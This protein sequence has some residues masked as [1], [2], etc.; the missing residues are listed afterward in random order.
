MDVDDKR[1]IAMKEKIHVVSVY[2]IIHFIVDFSCSIL[3]AG[4]IAPAAA[5][6]YNLFIG[7][8]LYNMFAFAFQL[9]FGL[10]ADK[11]NK[12]ALV[13][14]AG[15]GFIILAYMVSGFNVLSCVIAGIGNA[16]FHVGGGIDVL[17]ISNKR[18][19]LLGIYVAPGA[20]GLFLGGN[21]V[22]YGFNQFYAV[23]IILAVS[24]LVLLHLYK[25]VKTKY[26][27]N[28]ELP[29]IEINRSSFLI[30][31]CIL[32]T[33]CMR[34]YVGLILN[35]SWKAD[36]YTALAFVLGVV[37]G[38]IAGGIISDKFGLIRTSL[39][40]LITSAILFVFSF[41]NSFF[42]IAA[43]LLFN[44]TMPVTLIVL[45]NMFNNNKGFAFGLTTFAL[46]IGALPVLF[47]FRDVL[48]N[49]SGIFIIIVLSALAL[50]I[51]IKEY[52]KLSE[53]NR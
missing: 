13:S 24:I 17:N 7:I 14:S 2:S 4:L 51:G 12:N 53:S 46:F 16:L 45:S 23:V 31:A 32:F 18:A 36:F 48:F 34:G 35:F 44:M 30:A 11:L 40:S 5:G 29:L 25:A 28:N 33:V 37:S 43:V 22:K 47:G 6:T 9:P 50:Y 26:G 41:D 10:I 42:G 49:P 39:A 38:K 19:G 52:N 1:G 21:M 15:C 27:I 20:L 3:I 8:L